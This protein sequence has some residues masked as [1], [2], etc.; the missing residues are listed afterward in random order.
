MKPDRV[1]SPSMLVRDDLLY[2]TILLYNIICLYFQIKIFSLILIYH[3]SKNKISNC[4]T[5]L[6]KIN[7][8]KESCVYFVLN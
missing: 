3:E 6:K 5:D 7:Y 8:F 4:E 2:F 1:S